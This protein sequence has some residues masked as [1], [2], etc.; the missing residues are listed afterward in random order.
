MSC[1]C[2][3]KSSSCSKSDLEQL[4]KTIEALVDYKVKSALADMRCNGQKNQNQNNQNNNQNNINTGNLEDYVR[5]VELA[6]QIA[7]RAKDHCMQAVNTI[8]TMIAQFSLKLADGFNITGKFT[9][10]QGHE[11][12]VKHGII[13]KIKT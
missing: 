9:N 12:E 2:N 5:R 6:G 1:G 11:I 4:K 3:T 10:S 7:E 13:V 8:E